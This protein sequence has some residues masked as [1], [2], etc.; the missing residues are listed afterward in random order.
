MLE[1][2]KYITKIRFYFFVIIIVHCSVGV[3]CSIEFYG[4]SLMHY[5]FGQKILRFTGEVKKKTQ[6]SID[7]IFEEYICCFEFQ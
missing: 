7:P 4:K 6:H 1:Y 2:D 3:F 5:L